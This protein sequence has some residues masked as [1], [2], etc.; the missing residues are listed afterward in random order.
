MNPSGIR[1]GSPAVTT[2]GFG[3]AEMREVGALIAEVLDHM[4]D[5]ERHRRGAAASG[6]ADRALPALP[7]EARPGSSLRM[8]PLHIVIDARRIRDFGIGTYIRSLVQALS[9]IDTHQSLHPGDRAG[10]GARRSTACRRI[11]GT[12][13]YAREDD[14][15]LD[16]VLFPHVSARPVARPGAHSAEPRAAADDP[17]LR[18]DDARSWPTCFSSGRSTPSC[19]CSCGATGCCAGWRAP[20]A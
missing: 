18:G 14:S 17:A 4:A 15:H 9:A 2:R 1:L 20:A 19:A 8:A 10:R 12:S 16:N 6:S 7:V 5:A 11:S 13:V 3:E